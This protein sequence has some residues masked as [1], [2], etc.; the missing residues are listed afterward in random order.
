[1]TIQNGGGMF[2]ELTVN[3]M[4][5]LD[6]GAFWTALGGT[7]AIAA[8]PIV[9]CFNPLAGVGLALYGIGAIAS[10]M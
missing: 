3:E 8:A 2:T 9:S 7:I 4:Q 5:S 1:M 10:L 6:G